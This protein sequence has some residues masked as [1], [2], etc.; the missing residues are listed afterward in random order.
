MISIGW[1]TPHTRWTPA[2]QNRRPRH[3][4]GQLPADDSSAEEHEIDVIVVGSHDKS[5]FKRLVDP[6][7]PLESFA[8][9]TVQ[10][11]S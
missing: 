6:R 4:L 3:V 10:C 5:V 8:R 9:P 1:P 2:Q 11:S 7:W